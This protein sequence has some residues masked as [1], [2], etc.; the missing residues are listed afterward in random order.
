[1]K[2]PFVFGGNEVV[3]FTIWWLFTCYLCSTECNKHLR[4]YSRTNRRVLVRSVSASKLIELNQVYP[5]A[6]RLRLLGAAVHE[7][8]PAGGGLEKDFNS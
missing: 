6:F 1:M 2:T 4:A 5:L 7:L 8:L 3:D